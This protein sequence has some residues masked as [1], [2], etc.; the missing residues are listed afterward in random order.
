MQQFV[1]AL[2]PFITAMVDIL[3]SDCKSSNKDEI[4]PQFGRLSFADSGAALVSVFL[5]RVS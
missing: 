5:S 3:L 4:L 1:V 2:K